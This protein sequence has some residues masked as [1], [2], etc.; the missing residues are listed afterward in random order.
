MNSW[1]QLVEYYYSHYRDDIYSKVK[2]DEL[3]TIIEHKNLNNQIANK[4][5][6]YLKSNE[7]LDALILACKDLNI[8]AN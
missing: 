7:P 8:K 3:F 2:C 6:S 5:I 1:N 4:V